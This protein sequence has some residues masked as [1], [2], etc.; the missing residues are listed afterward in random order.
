M[1]N[2]EGIKETKQIEQF[3]FNTFSVPVQY[4]V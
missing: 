1:E 4:P 2:L 3:H